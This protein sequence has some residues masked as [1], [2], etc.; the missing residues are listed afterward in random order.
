MSKSGIETPLGV[1]EPLEEQAVVDR[2]E[3]GDAHRVRDDRAG[4]EPRPGPTRMPVLLGPVDQVGDDEEVARRSPSG[5]SRD[6]EVGTLA[7]L[8]GDAVGV[9]RRS[10]RSTSWRSHVSSVSPSGTGN[11]GINVSWPSVNVTSQRSAIS[12][13]VAGLGQLAE[14]VAHLLRRLEVVA[15]AVELEARR[16]RSGSTGLHAQQRVVADRVLLVR[17]VQVVGGDQAAVEVLREPQQVGADPPLDRR[18]RGPSARRSSC[19]PPNRSR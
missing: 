1:E 15:V 12:R 8:L 14:Q 7:D 19:R 2:V 16:R 17:V 9:A 11:R 18:A 13:V 4:A 10:P 3:V 6:L 5:G